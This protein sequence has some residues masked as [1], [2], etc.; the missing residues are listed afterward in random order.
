MSATTLGT[1][2]CDRTTLTYYH[3]GSTS[4]LFHNMH[5]L[6]RFGKPIFLFQNFYLK[7]TWGWDDETKRNELFAP[8][9]RHKSPPSLPVTSDDPCAFVHFRFEI[10]A[11]R[12]ILYCY[13]IQLHEKVRGF[14]LG[15]KL[16][17]ILL[18]ISIDNRM[19]RILLTVFK[20]NTVACTFFRKLGFKIDHTDPSKFGLC[21]DYSILSR[22]P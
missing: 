5:S 7:S 6:S 19:S 4:Y 8:E 18:K 11:G 20:F 14:K 3:S 21:V 16:M 1:W 12:P 10:D 2:I 15:R 9:S 13:E 17:D 22:R